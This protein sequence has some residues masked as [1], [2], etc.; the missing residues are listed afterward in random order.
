MTTSIIASDFRSI[1]RNLRADRRSPI[2]QRPVAAVREAKEK[3]L[4]A[5]PT[6]SSTRQYGTSTGDVLGSKQ[7]FIYEA[8]PVA[9]A[10]HD[11]SRAISNTGSERALEDYGSD[12]LQDITHNGM[13]EGTR[14]FLISERNS[15]QT[16]KTMPS[17]R[18]FQRRI[19]TWQPSQNTARQ[20][21]GK[22]H[23]ISLDESILRIQQNE[24]NVSIESS[25]DMM[26]S[27]TSDEGAL[28]GRIVSP[29]WPPFRP[30]QRVETPEGIPRWPLEPTGMPATLPSIR[31][32][33]FRYLHYG[34]A[35]GVRFRDVCARMGLIRARTTPP[36]AQRAIWRPPVSG[37]G[38]ARYN[39]LDTHPF[40]CMQSTSIGFAP[41]GQAPRLE[42]TVVQSTGEHA[43]ASQ[44]ASASNAT[45]ERRRRTM[46][47][48]LSP[49]QRALS[50][51]SGNAVPVTPERALSS[52]AA[53]R[54]G[55]SAPVPKSQGRAHSLGARVDPQGSVR[56]VE[57]I[58]SFPAPPSDVTLRRIITGRSTVSDDSHNMG[59]SQTSRKLRK[60]AMASSFI[61]LTPRSRNAIRDDNESVTDHAVASDEREGP[62]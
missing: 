45:L 7:S 19:L 36:N 35:S 61:M 58:D 5:V 42:Q 49:A 40:A 16:L 57:I 32:V 17:N 12:R 1:N 14:L 55:R 6:R 25:T 56:T 43:I 24:N 21:G 29:A 4:L 20:G 39:D 52:A 38:T 34:M 23:C 60:R 54:A 62:P 41:D 2:P 22:R 13:M 10:H 31:I 8:G 50:A 51:A 26:S 33:L 59:E 3:P 30:P 53:A 11:E 47:R 48:T 28:R 46:R 9:L 44:D 18:T 27:S 15:V 37:H